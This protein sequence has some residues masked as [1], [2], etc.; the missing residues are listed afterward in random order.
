MSSNAENLSKE[1]KVMKDSFQIGAITPQVYDS[2]VFDYRGHM[3]AFMVMP[4]Y[5][6]TLEKYLSENHISDNQL[7]R[8]GKQILVSL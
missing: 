6:E 4:R 3:W 7:L 1:I 8:I 5:K 2:G